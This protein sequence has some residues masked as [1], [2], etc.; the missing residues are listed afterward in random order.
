[1]YELFFKKVVVWGRVSVMAGFDSWGGLMVA[2]S[3]VVGFGCGDGRGGGEGEGEGE[4][5]LRGFDVFM[6]CLYVFVLK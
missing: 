5:W 3:A 4:W 6:S 1:M 2:I